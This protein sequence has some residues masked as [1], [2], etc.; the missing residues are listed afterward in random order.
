MS[1]YGKYRP[2]TFPEVIGQDLI[3]SALSNAIDNSRISQAYLFSGPRGCGKTSCARILARCLNCAKGPT[4]HPCGECESCIELG[5]GGSGSLDVMEIDAASHNSVE[6]ARN[7]REQVQFSPL[8]DRYKI[9]ILDEAHMISTQGFNALLKVVEE[10][11][12]NT[13]FIFATTA[14]EKVLATIRSRTVHYSFKLVEPGVMKKQ[15][16]YVCGQE[17]VKAGDEVLDMVVKQGGGSVRDCLS[18]LE[19]L[20]NGRSGQELDPER[21]RKILGLLPSELVEGYL[22][23]VL[24]FNAAAAYELGE[25]MGDFEPSAMMEALLESIRAKLVEN[26]KKGEEGKEASQLLFMSESIKDYSSLFKLS[27]SQSLSLDLLTSKLLSFSL[28][29][30]QDTSPKISPSPAL[31]P[32]S[33]ASSP[34]PLPRKA[35]APSQNK[36]ELREKWKKVLSDL[37][38]EVKENVVEEKIPD[39]DF[40]EGQGRTAILLT[41]ATPIDQHAFA[42]RLNRSIPKI[43]GE[44]VKKEFGPGFFIQPAKKAANGEAVTKVKDMSTEELSRLSREMIK[45]KPLSVEEIAKKVEG[46]VI[47]G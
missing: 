11:P 38:E 45:E 18:V 17:G 23:A 41:F 9:F 34:S 5:R 37:P 24:K 16:Q 42:L 36:E 33:F 30:S 39:I 22:E 21:C 12:K 15:L 32:S 47:E 6:D 10:P 19:E 46:K 43:V 7:L 29:G 14:P 13:V 3:T 28:S 20:I 1:L 27:L 4:S 2:E 26:F 31:P 8:R 44:A 35:A 40:E 25:K